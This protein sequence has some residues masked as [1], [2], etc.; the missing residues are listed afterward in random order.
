[1][2]WANVIRNGIETYVK[3]DSV[4]ISLLNLSESLLEGNSL[5]LVVTATNAPYEI[6]GINLLYRTLHLMHGN[7]V[8][9]RP[10]SFPAF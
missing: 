1:M 4:N 6:Q 3:A 9:N 2:I 10:G 5:T 8:T 7:R